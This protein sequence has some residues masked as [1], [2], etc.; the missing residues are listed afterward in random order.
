LILSEGISSSSPVEKWTVI[1]IIIPESR[2][3]SKLHTAKKPIATTPM[4]PTI[5]DHGF[6]TQMA[7]MKKNFSSSESI[8]P[9][10]M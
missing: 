6:L 10:H 3:L 4:I 8:I 5:N 2:L 9:Y 1:R 7:I